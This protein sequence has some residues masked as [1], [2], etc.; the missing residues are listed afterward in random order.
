MEP[1]T[2]RSGK[3]QK[4]TVVRHTLRNHLALRSIEGGL[5]SARRLR[6]C[7]RQYSNSRREIVLRCTCRS[8]TYP[9][10]VL[11]FTGGVTQKY[12]LIAV[13]GYV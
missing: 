10:P 4:I 9:C 6:L 7:R 5:G 13:L 3:P 1:S 8:G 2:A 12:Q 11:L